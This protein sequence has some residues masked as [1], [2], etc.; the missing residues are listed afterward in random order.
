MEEL[1]EGLLDLSDDLAAPFLEEVR[2]RDLLRDR[3]FADESFGWQTGSKAAA[4]RGL[5]RFDRDRAVLAALKALENPDAHDRE[6]YPYLI[7]EVAGAGAV[8][9]LL[10]QAV[11]EKSTSVIWAI[12]RALDEAGHGSVLAATLVA[13]D[14]PRR[15]AGARIAER[16]RVPEAVVA[17]LEALAENPDDADG[18]GRHTST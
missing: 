8:E 16:M 7:A 9:M 13:A 14:S 2:V 12:A 1:L 4:I 18:Y 10:D 5:A 17:M 15:L 11:A 6:H 3:S